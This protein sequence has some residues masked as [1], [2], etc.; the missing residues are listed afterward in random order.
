MAGEC[1]RPQSFDRRA[2]SGAVAQH[3]DVLR[4]DCPG[5]GRAQGERR[6]GE[7]DHGLG[8]EIEG[9]QQ[10]CEAGA[11]DDRPIGKRVDNMSHG[12]GSQIASMRST[13]R[14]APTAT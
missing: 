10:P 2:Q 14:R 6:L 13:A 3:T 12:E 1:E 5:A 4:H 7:H 11:D 8:R 9:S